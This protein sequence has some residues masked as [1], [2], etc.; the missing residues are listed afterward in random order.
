MIEP[1]PSVGAVYARVARER[2]NHAP[3]PDIL[4]QRFR[5]AWKKADSFDFSEEAWKEIVDYCFQPTHPEG[6]DED[7]FRNL[8]L[9]FATP[10]NWKLYPDVE[11]SLDLLKQSG[12]QVVVASNWDSRL[13][14]LLAGFGL[15]HYFDAVML[16]AEI[17]YHKPDPRFFDA[18]AARMRSHP[19][20]ILHVGDCL[21]RD[22]D[23]ARN[24]G[25]SAALIKRGDS[26]PA[27]T[28]GDLK[29]VQSLLELCDLSRIPSISI[30]GS[31]PEMEM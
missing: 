13:H 3:G 26:P 15:E 18:V 22:F 30:S 4:D 20:R 8:Y 12:L 10:E 28:D 6:V 11:L 14:N 27:H 7:L 25:F 9:A 23:A 21:V 16:S 29:A 31:T 5:E 2:F 24:S 19:S 1:F 17:G